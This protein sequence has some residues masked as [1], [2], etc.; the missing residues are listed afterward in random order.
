MFKP[1]S[2]TIDPCAAPAYSGPIGF[3]LAPSWFEPQTS[4]FRWWAEREAGTCKA[5]WTPT[6][7][8][9]PGCAFHQERCSPVHTF[10]LPAGLSVACEATASASRHHHRRQPPMRLR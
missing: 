9:H 2:E 8:E 1:E 7:T 5:S 4:T 6:E 10:T 3:G